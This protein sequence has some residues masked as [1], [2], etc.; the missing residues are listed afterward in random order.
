MGMAAEHRNRVPRNVSKLESKRLKG[1]SVE[2][3][4]EF[5]DKDENVERDQE[6]IYKRG[7]KAGLIVAKRNHGKWVIV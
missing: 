2:S 4:G 6:I 1:P 5:P 7:G 3:D